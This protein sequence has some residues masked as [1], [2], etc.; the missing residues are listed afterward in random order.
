MSKWRSMLGRVDALSAEETMAVLDAYENAFRQSKKLVRLNVPQLTICGDVH[1][2]WR[3]MQRIFEING[4]PSESNPYLFNGDFVD[5]GPNSRECILTLL[6][7]KLIDERSMFLNRGNHE[8]IEMNAYYGF[9]KELRNDSLFK[10]FNEVFSLLPVAHVVNDSL[11]VVHG[12]LPRKPASLDEISATSSSSQLYHELLWNDPCDSD[13]VHANPRGDGV[14]RF[15]P[16][17]TEAFLKSNK[18]NTL[19]RSHEMVE[20]GF[21]YSQHGKCV[22]VFSA[23]NYAGYYRNRGGFLRINSRGEIDP[24][25]FTAALT[26]KL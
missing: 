5:R 4:E 2:Q 6:L 18:L 9:R 16:D 15:G 20:A 13:G 11:F 19:V 10:R 14:Y 22:T 8:L 3:D 26:S 21:E 17:I 1:G 12:G 7:H 25:S 23:P 24:K